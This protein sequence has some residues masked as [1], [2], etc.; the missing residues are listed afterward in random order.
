M[1]DVSNI[2][3]EQWPTILQP[4]LQP[5]S[6]PTSTAKKNGIVQPSRADYKVFIVDILRPLPYASHFGLDQA[7]Q[8]VR[9][10]GATRNY[11]LGFNHDMNHDQ[12]LAIGEAVGEPPETRAQNSDPAVQAALDLVSEGPTAWMR[13]AFDGLR[14]LVPEA[15]DG[16]DAALVDG[17]G[18]QLN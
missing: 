5:G 6:G 3:D 13:P 18:E 16:P 9:K 7:V 8:A 11:V 12:W 1:S 10:L 17:Y 15:E 2:P 14:L 4:P